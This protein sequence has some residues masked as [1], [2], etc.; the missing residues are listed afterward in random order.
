MRR[1][2]RR[3]ADHVRIIYLERV[4][5]RSSQA[6]SLESSAVETREVENLRNF[7]KKRRNSAYTR[8]FNRDLIDI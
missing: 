7:D 5:C 1:K 4:T 3:Y 8:C 6:A 2:Y